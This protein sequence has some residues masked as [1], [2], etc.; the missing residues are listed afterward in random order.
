MKRRLA[1]GTALGLLI[2]GVAIAVAQLVAAFVG[3]V[4]SPVV[5]VGQAAIDLAPP[6]VKD[7]AIN[8]FGSHDKAVLVAG[9][10]VVLAVFAA[11]IGVASLRLGLPRR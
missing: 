3:D 10:L 9:I 1:Y 7:F 6:S 5:A 11:L 2:A 4:S 8:T